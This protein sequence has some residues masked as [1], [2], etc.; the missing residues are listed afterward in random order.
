[1]FQCHRL[2]HV[3][4]SQNAQQEK[5]SYTLLANAELAETSVHT[6]IINGYRMLC[7]IFI[8]DITDLYY[9]KEG[10]KAV[11]LPAGSATFTCT[12]ETSCS[13]L[14]QCW[15]LLALNDEICTEW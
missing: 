12:A 3:L 8:Y 14:L 7:I 6:N 5:L 15:H 13:T 9:K 1:L 2:V 4:R 11:T 10:K